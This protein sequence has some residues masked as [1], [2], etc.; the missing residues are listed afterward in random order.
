MTLD[1]QLQRH[2]M[3]ELIRNSSIRHAAIGV[4]VEKGIVTLSGRVS[5]HLQKLEVESIIEKTPGVKA[6]VVHLAV[7]LTS[8]SL[9]QDE[10]IAFAV[11]DALRLHPLVPDGLKI[12]VANGVVTLKGVVTWEYEREAATRAVL[13]VKS[14]IYVRNL[15]TIL[16]LV[17]A[18]D[19]KQRIV[20][21]LKQNAEK[22]ARALDV[23]IRGGSVFLKG[24]V[25]S[26]SELNT[27][28]GVIQSMP[29]LSLIETHLTVD[30]FI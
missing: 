30:Q 14:V 28:R 11:I 10:D 8:A 4:S 26:L 6:V 23:D 24:R 16:D 1:A 25:R 18:K 9:N 21:R 12:G 2:I 27:V 19:I 29:G 5:S 7:R 17:S 3:E 13:E 15:V 22:E 20:S